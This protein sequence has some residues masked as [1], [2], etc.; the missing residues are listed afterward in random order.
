METRKRSLL[1]ETKDKHGKS[2]AA[3]WSLLQDLIHDADVVLEIVDARDIEGTR[4]GSAEKWAGS[5]RLV[6]VVNKCDLLPAKKPWSAPLPG[7]SIRISA[8]DHSEETRLKLLEA[9]RKRARALPARGVVV[10]Y[11]N[12][13]KSSIINLLAKRRAAKVTPVA[14]TTT[15]VQWVRVAD[16]VLISDYPGVYPS[17]EK[18]SILVQKG[19]LNVHEEADRYAHEFAAKALR[20]PKLLAWLEI[21]FDVDL[22]EAKDSESILAAIAIRRGWLLKRGE[23]NTEEASRAVLRAMREAPEID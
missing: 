2:R 4:L 23:P 7:I 22:T 17:F 14:G 6:I 10:G 19:A 13:G 9:I 21:F 15:N 11:P 1:K 20:R 18:K 16:D 8:K 5:N 12:V 3:N